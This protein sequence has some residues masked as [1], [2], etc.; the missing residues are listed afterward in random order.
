MELESS[1][2]ETPCFRPRR[3]W[4]AAVLSL[5]GSGPLGQVYVGRLRRGIL[6]WLAGTVVLLI[7]ALAATGLR[8][9]CLG[10]IVL[11]LGV[12]G[13]PIW[14]AVDAF[15]LARRECLSPRKR[16]Q[17]WWCY[18]ILFAVFC[19][20]NNAAAYLFRSFVGEAFLVPT[21]GMSPTIL[22]GERI[23]V[24]KLLFSRGHLRRGEVVM[25]RSEGRDSLLFVQRLV[26]LPG[27]E[28]QIRN[29]RVFINGEEWGDPHA[30]RCGPVPPFGSMVDYGPTKVPAGCYFFLGDN[31]RLSKDSRVI[32][33]IPISDVYG[34]A[35]F[36]YWSRERTFPDPDDTRRYVPGPFHWDRVG[37]RLD[38]LSD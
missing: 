17:R 32:G 16:Y 22:P 5:L 38:R 8:I 35:R 21:R 25:F 34:V 10:L 24:D 6:L 30:V 9:G 36:V 19:L 31:R 7:L 15:L 1:A 14:F 11:C 33:P 27:D 13:I 12:V 28:I 4:L 20:G 26:G 2:T 3:P 29:E 23:L 18:V 37:L